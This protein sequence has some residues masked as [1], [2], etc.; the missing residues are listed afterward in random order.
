MEFR[1]LK[2]SLWC[3]YFGVFYLLPVFLLGQKCKEDWLNIAQDHIDSL[4]WAYLPN[5]AIKYSDSITKKIELYHLSHCEESDWI[6]YKYAE[7]MELNYCFKGA[8]EIYNRLIKKYSETKNNYF[9]ASCHI[10]IARCMETVGNKSECR[11]QLDIAKKLI[12]NHD[13]TELLAFYY[14]RESSYYR[15]INNKDSAMSCAK[16]AFFWV[17]S[18]GFKW[19][20]AEA[21]FLMGILFENPDSAV[22]FLKE[23]NA[24][25]LE[26]KN[27]VAASFMSLGI[28]NKLKQ[29]ES[30]S[31]KNNHWLD[32]MQNYLSMIIECSQTCIYARSKYM[33]SRASE[34]E[35]LKNK[36]SAY[37]YL[38]KS[39][40]QMNDYYLMQ[41]QN[42]VSLS[43]VNTFLQSERIKTE[44]LTKESRNQ[45]LLLL[46]LGIGFLIISAAL[47]GNLRK[48]I[49]IE[50]QQHL[51]TKQNIDLNK[52]LDRQSM[53]LT[54]VHHRVKNNLQLIISLLTLQYSKV[55]TS[56]EYH[57]L[58]DI[59]SKIRS[60]ALI[61]EHLY[62]TGEFEKIELQ[63]YLKA[64][65]DH[66]LALHTKA[67]A[68]KYCVQCEKPIYLNLETVIPIGIICTE[69]IS[70]SLKY[71]RQDNTILK[72]TFEIQVVED[73]YYLKYYDREN[74]RGMTDIQVVKPGMGTLLIE[75]MV[76]QLQAQSS[77]LS[78]GTSTFSLV[79]HEK[80]LSIV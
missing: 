58:E 20:K 68:F 62:S 36:D 64:L 71:G 23:A 6:E 50:K 67:L 26:K 65:L 51:I 22:Y 24:L 60:I 44:N 53:L 55:K 14:I 74:Y 77:P 52:S 48:R 25:Y 2:Q 15:A 1:K 8:I 78:F 69:L 19:Y 18:S 76:R 5:A 40:A 61:H 27:Y 4:V 7:A 39:Y 29:F 17:N 43:E 73:K 66:Y 49:K 56:G 31:L 37:I 63:A 45:K 54:E 28:Y 13:I 41:E 10:S 42:D 30:G 38:K 75:S 35:D 9:I 3:F 59:S 12:L 11:N 72:L 79:F 21:C 46:I 57:Y 80:K 70:N 34:F 33:E 32:S 16:Q 47:Y